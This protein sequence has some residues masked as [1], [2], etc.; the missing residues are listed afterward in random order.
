METANKEQKLK[1]NISGKQPT[2]LVAGGTGFLG[3]HLCE[4]LISQKF[5]VIAVDNLSGKESKQNIEGLLS[6]P[7]FSFWE[8]DINKPGFTISPTIPISHIFHLASIEERLTSSEISLQ[9]L[10]VNSL[11]TKNLLDLA[12]E[13]KA[14]FILVS[15]TEV[16]HG[17]ISQTS[18]AAYF[19]Q[20][21]D[22]IQL[23]FSEAKR[24]AETLTAEYFKKYNLSTTIIRIKDPYGPRMNLAEENTLDK[25]IS[26]AIFKRKIE[27]VG[28]GLQTL[29][30]TYVSDIIFG[31]VKTTLHQAKGEIFNLINPEKFTERAIAEHL[32]R[33]IG[34]V[35]IVYKK[36]EKLELPFYPLIL[37]PSEEK[38][39]WAPK[40]SLNQGLSE[41]IAFYKE[42]EGGV[43]KETRE[44]PVPKVAIPEPKI[45]RRG[46]RWSL[47]RWLVFF[48]SSALVLWLVA[49]P[50]ANLAINTYLG[51]KNLHQAVDKLANDKS[52]VSGQQAAKAEGAYKNG[53]KLSQNISWLGNLLRLKKTMKETE[54][55]L[56]LAENLSTTTRLSAEAQAAIINASD[57]GLSE[58]QMIENLKTARNKT[59]LAKKSLEIATTVRCEEGSLPTPL[60]AD[61]QR[62]IDAEKK[63]TA[64]IN[65]IDEAL[66]AI[67]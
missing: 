35:E 48:F 61:Y 3:S 53:E 60:R 33:I 36:E 56:F 51:N 32:K 39:G 40:V 64:F 29:N 15:S 4:A 59:D 47:L 14:K 44:I 42:K 58:E 18:V 6:S 22:P 57:G 17:A 54:N 10:L 27:I 41:T 20:G 37:G 12:V 11:G 46:S 5:N 66:R 24:F 62:L 63:L 65:S 26:Q 25:L 7:N 52:Q 45:T 55:Y 28:D 16:F 31:I 43:E 38:L 50:I 21:A 1:L 49:L 67:F 2:A 8:E 23:S 19:E 9:T 13:K 34:G 30:P